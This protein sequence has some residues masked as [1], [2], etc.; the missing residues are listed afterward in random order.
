VTHDL[1]PRT[2]D[3]APLPTV[4]LRACR[5]VAALLLRCWYDVQVGG[6][7]HVPSHGAVLLVCNHIGLLDGPL[8]TAVAP[9]PVHGLV[10]KEMFDGRGRRPLRALGQISVERAAVDAMAV[11]QALRVLRD[12]GVVAVYPEGS[13][14]RGDVRHSR[15]GAAYLALASG[16]CVVPVAHLGTRPD[17]S[18]V[19]A[20]PA[21]GSRLDVLFGPPL[22]PARAPVAW[23]RRRAVVTALAE[24]LRAGLAAHVQDC[25]CRTG[26]SL[27]GEPPDGADDQDGRRGPEVG[28]QATGQ[29]S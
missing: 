20:V 9:R 3:V 15:L 21:R 28:P 13:R 8:L 1:L 14:G 10:K 19:H 23:P 29:A 16:A 11:K 7:R 12:G 25:V 4:T 18:S 17:G 24:E 5:R 27:P 2:T 26:R 22:R 6:R